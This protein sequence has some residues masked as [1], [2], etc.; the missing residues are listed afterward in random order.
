MEEK[1]PE[2]V[3]QLHSIQS[4]DTIESKSIVIDPSVI[5]IQV[6][7]SLLPMSHIIQY[8]F[9]FITVYSHDITTLDK[10]QINFITAFGRFGWKIFKCWYYSS[11]LHNLDDRNFS[12]IPVD[13]ILKIYN[14]TYKELIV[15]GEEHRN[16]V[17]IITH[18]MKETIPDYDEE[19]LEFV[20][21][22]SSSKRYPLLQV[23]KKLNPLT[24]AYLL[25]HE[26]LYLEAYKHIIRMI[27]SNLLFR[28]YRILEE[29]SKFYNLPLIFN[30]KTKNEVPRLPILKDY[31][32]NYLKRTGKIKS[33][34]KLPL[35]LVNIISGEYF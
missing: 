31:L 22:L 27:P 7:L 24:T 8:Y 5:T 21:Y 4:K 1:I 32:V 18:A 35:D 34:T 17:N 20:S 28:A 26:N 10:L 15:I 12:R 25:N 30:W 9:D 6:L 14:K 16:V 2:I 29:Y 33:A 13:K 11:F 19:L 3:R 23:I